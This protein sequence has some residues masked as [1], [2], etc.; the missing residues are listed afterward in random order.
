MLRSAHR[1][2]CILYPSRPSRTRQLTGGTKV[3]RI[4]C[5]L[6]PEGGVSSER[7][8]VIQDAALRAVIYADMFDYPLSAAE[9]ARYLPETRSTEGEVASCFGTP[10][11]SAPLTRVGTQYCLPGREAIVATRQRRLDHSKPLWRRA[12][13]IS[14]ILSLTPFVRMVAVTGA[15][16]VDNAIEGDDVDLLV[17]TAPGRVWTVRAFILALGRLLPGPKLCPNYVISESTLT[18]SPRDLYRAREIAQMVPLYGLETY[19][20]MLDANGWARTYLPN[21]FDDRRLDARAPRAL[22]SLVKGA[23]ERIADAVGIVA[24]ERWERERRIRRARASGR[25]PNASAILDE[26]QCK[27]H[28]TDHA[29]MILRR[30]EQALARFGLTA[31]PAGRRDDSRAA[32]HAYRD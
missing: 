25:L 21:A 22:S 15:L 1:G 18:L 5:V 30:Y 6:A 12:S 16:A 9:I 14:G 32:G 26:E 4:L 29:A 2:I 7:R 31:E 27:A 23:L 10:S 19:R 20:R 13:A 11:A 24:L 28:Y 17:V 8:R 3:S